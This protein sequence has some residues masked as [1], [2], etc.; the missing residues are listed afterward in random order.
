MARLVEVRRAE[1]RQASA[2]ELLQR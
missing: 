2:G 1:V